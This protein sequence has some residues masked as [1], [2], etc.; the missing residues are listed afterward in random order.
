[1]TSEQSLLKA[2][3]V[4]ADGGGDDLA[5]YAAALPF[6]YHNHNNNCGQ[7]QSILAKESNQIN[8]SNEIEMKSHENS[9]VEAKENSS[10]IKLPGARKLHKRILN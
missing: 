6:D 5:L 4:K 1:M 8:F 2:A 9:S 10:K 3:P 7:K